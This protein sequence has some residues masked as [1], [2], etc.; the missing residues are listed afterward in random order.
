MHGLMSV[1][2][3]LRHMGQVFG[4]LGKTKWPHMENVSTL[5]YF[6]QSLLL[7]A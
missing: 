3:S 7:Q 6:L 5:K 4:P 1:I 2:L